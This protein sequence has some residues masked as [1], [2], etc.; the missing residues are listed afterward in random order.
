MIAARVGGLGVA[1]A[2]GRTGV[3]VDGH[4]I[5]A[6][7]RRLSELLADPARRADMGRAAARH[8]TQ[9][10]WEHTTDALL[11]SYSRAMSAF[12][13]QTQAET[14][15]FGRRHWRNRARMMV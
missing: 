4:G 7:T 1:V 14:G 6:W 9:F 3:L 2:D 13:G 11:A 8:A 5:D 12:G 15:R 10:S